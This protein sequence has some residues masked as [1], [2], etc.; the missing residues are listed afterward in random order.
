MALDDT[1]RA[2]RWLRDL[3]RFLPLKSQFVLTGNIRDLQLIEASPG[4]V[5]PV[6]LATALAT[7]LI[8]KGYRH[9]VAYEPTSGFQIAPSL[10]SPGGGD[11]LLSHLG[12]TPAE[13]IAPAGLDLLA[14]TLGPVVSYPEGPIALLVDFASRLIVRNELLQPHEH[15]LFTR[16]QVLSH[17]ARP[18]PFGQ[19]GTPF[20]NPILWIVDKEGDLPDWFLFNNA[21]L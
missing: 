12:L 19:H 3:Q 14:A 5:V 18:R 8:A 4:Q 15:Q 13:G 11:A 21:R 7:Q 20:F 9:V 1:Y 10:S 2:P 17:T 16:A 6:P